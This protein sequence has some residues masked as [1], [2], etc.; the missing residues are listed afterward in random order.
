MD[1]DERRQ[2]H[3]A[4]ELKRNAALERA[5]AA[6]VKAVIS[7]GAV[8]DCASDEIKANIRDHWWGWS[9]QVWDGFWMAVR[10]SLR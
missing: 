7:G 1:A 2:A 4:R 6:A 3:E 5:K 9:N 10:L 8:P